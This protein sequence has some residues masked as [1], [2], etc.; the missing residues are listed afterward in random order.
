MSQQTEILALASLWSCEHLRT[1]GGILGMKGPSLKA[2]ISFFISAAPP[3]S[4]RDSK[5]RFLDNKGSHQN[6]SG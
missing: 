6:P 2:F 3:I 1:S 4:C 5:L